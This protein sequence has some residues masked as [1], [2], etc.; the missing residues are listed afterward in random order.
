MGWPYSCPLKSM[1]YASWYFKAEVQSVVLFI[2]KEEKLHSCLDKLF[3]LP[4]SMGL[5]FEHP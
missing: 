4:I 5:V 1:K 3:I 2:N